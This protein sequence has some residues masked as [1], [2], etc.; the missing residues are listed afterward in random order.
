MDY[1]LLAEVLQRS[2]NV[3]IA[4]FVLRE[5]EYS[6]AVKSVD[7]VILLIILYYKNGIV[8]DEGIIPK[9]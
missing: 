7:G 9:Q 5:R 2:G 1:K 3:E 4:K 8:S 6:V